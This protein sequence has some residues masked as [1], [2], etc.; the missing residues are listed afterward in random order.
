MAIISLPTSIGGVSIPGGVLNG[1]LGSLFG[2]KSGSNQYQYPNDIGSNPTRAHSVLF[3]ILDI[4][5]NTLQEQKTTAINN[6][7]SGSGLSSAVSAASSAAAAAYNSSSGLTSIVSPLTSGFGAAVQSVAP[8][9]FAT[10]TSLQAALKPPIGNITDNITLYMP[11]TL[12]MSYNANWQEFSLTDELGGLGRIASAAMDAYET[13]N[14]GWNENLKNLASGPAGLDLIGQGANAITGGQQGSDILL[15]SGGYAIN[16][17]LQLLYK[18]VGLRSFQMEFLFTPK[19][20]TEAQAVKTIISRF[21]R[22]FLPTL[23]GATK[24]G[25]SGQYFTM[26]SVFQIK[27]QFHGGNNN[28]PAGAAINSV[29]G[30]LGAVGTAIA[31]SLGAGSTNGNENTYLYKVGNCVLE[32]LTVDYAPNGWAAYT[33]GGPVQTRLTLSFKETDIMH[34]QIFDSKAV[35]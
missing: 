33:D 12:N 3:T 28:T 11:E 20:Q 32:D 1:P 15:R 17:Q 14:A 23:Q 34:R 5:P 30:S 2:K 31:P 18:G 9:S 8:G 22:A 29:L 6:L 27:F 13:R 25:S 35:R 19:S 16:P 10:T 7:L 4:N 26:P 21:T 24:G